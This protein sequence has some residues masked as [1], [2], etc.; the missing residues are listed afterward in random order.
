MLARYTL[1]TTLFCTALLQSCGGGGGSSGGNG[2]EPQPFEISGAISIEANS[3]VDAD[4]AQEIIELG[5]PRATEPLA[6]PASVILG[7]FISPAS[8]TYLTD[9]PDEA[10]FEYPSDPVD[11]Y[12][13][14]LEPGQSVNVQL[15]TAPVRETPTSLAPDTALSLFDSD[16][17]VVATSAAA[18][19]A[20]AKRVT[21]PENRVAG[22]YR[23]RLEARAGS[24][25]LRYILTSSALS[26]S[27]QASWLSSEFV[28]GEAVVVQQ[29]GGFQASQFVAAEASMG[30]VRHLGQDHY[31][32][33]MPKTFSAVGL[34]PL[35][36]AARKEQTLDWIRALRK[37]P[38]VVVAD[39]NYRT[40][41]LGA[42]TAQEL[43]PL[44]WHYP[45]I[46]LPTAWQLT[47]TDTN[48]EGGS[49]VRIAVLDTGVFFNGTNWHE[50]LT[51]NIVNCDS[52]TTSGCFDA[53]NGGRPI[54]PG[55]SVGSSVFHGTHVAGTAAATA[56]PAPGDNQGGTG[57]AYNATLVPVRVLDGDGS[58]TSADLIEGIDWVT[59][60]DGAPRADIINL[61]LG[62][63]PQLVSVQAAINRAVDRGIVV[64][65][66]SGNGA[67]NIVDYPAAHDNV[68]AVGAVDGAANLS[69]FSNTGE[70]LDLVAPGGDATR[71]ANG[72]GQAD[73]IISSSGDNLSE[74]PQARYIGLQGTSMAAPH[75]SGVFALMK[76]MD[77]GVNTSSLEALLT[78]NQ[79]TEDRG[80]SGFD[81]DYGWG[82]IDAAKSV[83]AVS[84]GLPVLLVASPAVLDFQGDSTEQQITLTKTQTGS[85][86]TPS[87]TKSVDWLAVTPI[88]ADAQNQYAFRVDLDRSK[89][90]PQ[91]AYR[92]TITFD[93]VDSNSHSRTLEVPVTASLES[94]ENLRNAGVHF[95]LL[96]DPQTNETLA[97]QAVRAVDGVYRFSFDESDD[98]GPGNYTLIAG[99]DLDNDGIICTSGEACAEYPI[100]GLREAFTVDESGRRNLDMTTAFTRPVSAES[101]PRPGFKGYKLLR[102]AS[103]LDTRKTNR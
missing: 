40:R 79:L 54:D 17:N 60:S 52:N 97:Q 11:E 18:A 88:T 10:V 47:Q 15:F 6:V 33:R 55:S 7:G 91:K 4:S 95:V 64:V 65:A 66:A 16:D 14:N 38:D 76:A 103:E 61:S 63:L 37:R 72:D 80:A 41:A 23:V 30:Q 2:E 22:V 96:L 51:G 81:S 87:A 93:Y 13:I 32:V 39:P 36:E 8:G 27:R 49:N 85:T 42:P 48:T 89:L 70:R 45:L 99:T 78:D 83:E 98:I 94:D 100:A 58:G 74:P 19:D 86:S 101:L 35:T 56:G 50:D 84:N 44:Q 29:A 1:F 68:F 5:E 53:I 34:A 90:D 9:S 73:V 26:Q 24:A 102:K 57:V 69:S 46:S 67:Q 12:S 20:T 3:R 77:G 59:N 92:T 82:V 31:L 43:F 62:G 75:V 21:L 25:P 71:D 28:P